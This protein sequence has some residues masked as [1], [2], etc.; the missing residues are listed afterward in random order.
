MVSLRERKQNL[1]Q[2]RGKSAK[3]NV[4]RSVANGNRFQVNCI[5]KV[6][7]KWKKLQTDYWIK[8]M[9]W[10]CGRRFS[11]WSKRTKKNETFM[12]KMKLDWIRCSI[13]CSN[14]IYKMRSA[15]RT[16]S[17]VW[18]QSTGTSSFFLFF[19]MRYSPPENTLPSVSDDADSPK[20][21]TI[22]LCQCELMLI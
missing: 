13:Y 2:Q 3:C 21:R 1:K 6:A 22:V 15:T 10:M 11:E 5:E 9:E 18:Q 14:Q 12:V 7:T 8:Q 16:R 20:R 4:K 19:V 17:D